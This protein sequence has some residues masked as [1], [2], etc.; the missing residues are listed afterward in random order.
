MDSFFLDHWTHFLPII[1]IILFIGIDFAT[2][3]KKVE[4]PQSSTGQVISITFMPYVRRIVYTLSIL[5][6]LFLYFIAAASNPSTTNALVV[7]QRYYGLTALTLIYVVLIPGLLRAYLPTFSLNPLLI[8]SRRAIGLSVFS[9]ATVHMLLGFFV[10]L[11]GS[12]P[13]I[14]LLPIQNQW[15]ILFSTTAYTIFLL[16][17]ATSFDVMVRK[18]GPKRW[19]MLHRFVY[20]AAILVVFHA[21]F[22]GSNFTNTKS[23]IPLLVNFTTLLIILLEIGATLKRTSQNRDHIS[24]FRFGLIWMA[25]GI[26]A[27]AAIYCSF[28]GITSN[29]FDPHAEHRVASSGKYELQLSTISSNITPGKP[30][31]VTLKIVDGT[32]GEQIKQFQVVHEKLMHL[33]VLKSDLS[34]YQ[35]L[36][37]TLERDGDFTQIVSFSSSGVYNF[38]AEFQ[39]KGVEPALARSSFVTSGGQEIPA[40]ITV[41]PLTQNFGEYQVQLLTRDT[42]VG[43]SIPIVFQVLDARTGKPV[44]DLEP[45]LGSFGHLVVVSEDLSSYLHVHP[46]VTVMDERERGGPTVEFVTQFDKPGKYKLYFQFQR[47]GKV[48]LAEYGIEVK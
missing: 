31:K 38:F 14:F 28:L 13:A 42:T 33:V 22:I 9:F 24:D 29:V 48:Q 19:K 7:L 6:A 5:W 46:S 25:M 26:F 3:G 36:H 23:L 2:R 43:K 10:N 44:T 16:M 37:P 17:A 32:T 12:I 20:L 45:Y 30:Y 21:F 4:N 40:K 39:P 47:N 8:R 34:S 35:H 41:S 1:P 11:S 18:L 15:A 27:V